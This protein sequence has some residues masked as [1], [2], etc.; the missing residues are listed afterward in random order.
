MCLRT[1]LLG[2]CSAGFILVSLGHLIWSSNSDVDLDHSGRPWNSFQWTS[3]DDRVRGGKSIS[4]LDIS[5][6]KVCAIFHGNLDIKTLGG[7]GFASQRTVPELFAPALDL[8]GYGTL[9]IDVNLSASDNKTYTLILKDTEALPRRPDGREQST[10]SWE[11]DFRPGGSGSGTGR[12]VMRFKDFK[13]T[14]RGRP[15]P[16]AEPLNLNKILAMSIMM[17]RYVQFTRTPLRSSTTSLLSAERIRLEPKTGVGRPLANA[18]F[19]HFGE[20]EG[21]FS[22][23]LRSIAAQRHGESVSESTEDTESRQSQQGEAIGVT[24]PGATASKGGW[25]SWM[26]SMLGGQR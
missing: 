17:R 18:M 21:D 24:G 11:Y 19:S 13:P 8:S 3:V 22:L 7:A 16:D 2:R 5:D 25:L 23:A 12:L 9:V 1:P 4:H 15:K 14:Y 26:G 10:V 20:Q 6:S